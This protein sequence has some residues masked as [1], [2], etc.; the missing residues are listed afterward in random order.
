MTH[1]RKTFIV[2]TNVLLND[3]SCIGNFGNNDVMIPMT[4]FEEL[5]NIK[6]RNN[7][8]SRDAR[9]VIRRLD[10]I[11][12]YAS[13]E[14][15]LAGVAII[16]SVIGTPE[17]SLLFVV[18]DEI[19]E[20]ID[21]TVPDNRIISTAL[22]YQEKGT[23]VVLISNDINM[24]LKAKSLGVRF[25]ESHQNEK[26]VSDLDILHKGYI[27]IEGD[28]Y[29]LAPP[30]ESKYSGKNYTVKYKK[31]E[32][33]DQLFNSILINDY[34]LDSNENILRFTGKNEES[35]FFIDI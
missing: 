29:E 31:D 13:Y 15:L 28:V 30:V 1:D 11:I 20:C 18:K 32:T 6:S 26:S 19:W 35:Y 14:E 5:D 22:Y 25:V 21:Q 17:D 9:A 34:I 12:G 23:N 24:R 33:T 27:E 3:P 4:V 2:D 7:D 8:V 10:Y 16:N